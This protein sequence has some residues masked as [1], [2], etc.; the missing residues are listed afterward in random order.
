MLVLGQV[1]V[2]AYFN[3]EEDIGEEDQ[4]IILLFSPMV[5]PTEVKP[6]TFQLLA[7]MLYCRAVGDLVVRP[8]NYNLGRNLLNPCAMLT[9]HFSCDRGLHFTIFQH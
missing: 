5:L 3:Q 6:M 9:K 2:T 4:V 7:C 8:L 1:H